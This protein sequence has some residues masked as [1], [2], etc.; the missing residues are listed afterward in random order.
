MCVNMKTKESLII[1]CFLVKWLGQ[2]HEINSKELEM[3]AV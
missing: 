1:D 3:I 2:L